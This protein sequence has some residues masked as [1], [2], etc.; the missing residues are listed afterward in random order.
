LIYQVDLKV[1]SV[2][3]MALKVAAMRRLNTVNTAIIGQVVDVWQC[4]QS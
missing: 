4:Q 3:V 2:I 1:A